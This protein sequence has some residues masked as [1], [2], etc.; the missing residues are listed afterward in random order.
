MNAETFFIKVSFANGRL[1]PDQ[2]VLSLN[3]KP[4]DDF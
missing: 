4:K 2:P 3:A 1:S